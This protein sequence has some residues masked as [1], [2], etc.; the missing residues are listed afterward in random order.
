MLYKTD[1]TESCKIRF[2]DTLLY[3]YKWGTYVKDMQQIEQ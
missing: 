2:L 3:N 1:P